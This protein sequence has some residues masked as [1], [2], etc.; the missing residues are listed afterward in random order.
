MKDLQRS[1]SAGFVLA[2]AL[3]ALAIVSI[4]IGGAYAALFQT[5]DRRE[6]ALLDLD[7]SSV[8]KGMLLEHIAT[9]AA[10]PASGTIGDAWAWEIEEVVISSEDAAAVGLDLDVVELS[11]T[12]WSIGRPSRT[13]TRSTAVLRR[14]GA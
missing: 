11:V 13:L 8:A 5:L 10:A 6:R 4:V 12:V 9:G 1:A 3:A 14:P 7:L 2:D